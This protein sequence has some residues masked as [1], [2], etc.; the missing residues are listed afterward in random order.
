MLNENQKNQDNGSFQRKVSDFIEQNLVKDIALNLTSR[1]DNW[2][3]IMEEYNFQILW[4][5]V[6][7]A[8]ISYDKKILNILFFETSNWTN[9]NNTTSKNISIPWIWRFSIYNFIEIAKEKWLEEIIFD[10]KETELW[11]YKK[12]LLELTYYKWINNAEIIKLKTKFIFRIS[13]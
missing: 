6:L 3:Q 12:M 9:K 13:I 7:N 8:C 5:E 2:V 1:L 4:E 11:F 10:I